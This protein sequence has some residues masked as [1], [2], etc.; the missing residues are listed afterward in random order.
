MDFQKY[1]RIIAFDKNSLSE[2]QKLSNEEVL[3]RYIEL[4]RNKRSYPNDYLLSEVVCEMYARRMPEVR[5]TR[6]L[7][8]FK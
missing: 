1:I 8:L 3:N 2:L 6:L 5:D 7:N 4:A